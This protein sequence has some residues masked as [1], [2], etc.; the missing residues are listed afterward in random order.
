MN[1]GLNCV[2]FAARLFSIVAIL[3]GVLLYGYGICVCMD[4][5]VDVDVDVRSIRS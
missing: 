1:Q 2:I 5:A 3:Y 4:M